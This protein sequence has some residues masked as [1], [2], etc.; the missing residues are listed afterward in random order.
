MTESIADLSRAIDLWPGRPDWHE[1]RGKTRWLLGMVKGGRSEANR[2]EMRGA[3]DDF[4]RCVELDPRSEARLKG[5][6]ET[7]RKVLGE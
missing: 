1:T 5:L 4:R 7:C 3:L 6:M 2:D